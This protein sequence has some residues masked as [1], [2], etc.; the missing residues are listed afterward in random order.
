MGGIMGDTLRASRAARAR[1]SSDL[2][3]AQKSGDIEMNAHP[4]WRKVSTQ[5]II[6]LN[7]KMCKDIT[8][9]NFR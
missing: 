8:S 2:Q 7:H 1:L 3:T 4:H 9:A 5:D 6:Q